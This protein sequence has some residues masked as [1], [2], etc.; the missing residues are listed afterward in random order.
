ME[1]VVKLQDD[2]LY[3][4]V[5]DRKLK[6]FE[7]VYPV[8]R[9]VTYNSY[10]L[11]DECTVLM[12]TVDAGVSTQFMEN[13][14]AALG[15]RGLDYVVVNHV[16]PDHVALLETVLQR[17]SDAVVVTNTK[18]AAML[19]QFYG[20]LL[21]NRLKIV[22]SIELKKNKSHDNRFN[23][24]IVDLASKYGKGG[25]KYAAKIAYSSISSLYDWD[26]LFDKLK[27]QKKQ[28]KRTGWWR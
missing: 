9:G 26:K 5:S 1:N 25:K 13:V 7:N 4:G 3:V 10:L 8:E 23:Y 27:A 11:L 2:L 21:E 19:G 24:L 16:E 14:T 20:G 12:D 6:L 15:E 28:K 22:K 18:A 17:W